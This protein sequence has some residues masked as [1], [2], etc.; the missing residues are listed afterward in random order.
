M[1]HVELSTSCKQA[2]LDRSITELREHTPVVSAETSAGSEP[3]Q[4]G[5]LLEIDSY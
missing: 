3:L 5:F 1:Y 2:Q 4:K